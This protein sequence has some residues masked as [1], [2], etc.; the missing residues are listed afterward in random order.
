LPIKV[1]IEMQL[2]AAMSLPIDPVLSIIKPIEIP[3]LTGV[4]RNTN[5][6]AQATAKHIAFEFIP[7]LK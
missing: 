7:I 1:N 4:G 3:H 6:A 2:T 5:R